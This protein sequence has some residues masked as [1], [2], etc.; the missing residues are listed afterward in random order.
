MF[1]PS[2]KITYPYLDDRID[3]DSAPCSPH[4]TGMNNYREFYDE[5]L[6]CYIDLDA[7]DQKLPRKVLFY[8]MDFLEFFVIVSIART[9]WE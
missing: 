3:R 5:K 1:Y 7:C 2:L 6:S 9:K 4:T 8:M